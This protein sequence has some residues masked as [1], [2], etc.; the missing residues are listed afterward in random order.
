MQHRAIIFHHGNH[1]TDG[2]CLLGSQQ[3]SVLSSSL[4]HHCTNRRNTHRS[5]IVKWNNV[6][7]CWWVNKF[8]SSNIMQSACSAIVF[9]SSAISPSF[10]CSMHLQLSMSSNL[11]A[12]FEDYTTKGIL[13]Y[14][15]TDCNK[16]FVIVIEIIIWQSDYQMY[17]N[18]D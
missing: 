6:C 2:M 1:L 11:F 18:K 13:E 10:F 8:I 3:A 16:S 15:I 7:Y 14:L 12:Q 4:F 17:Q 9:S 5:A